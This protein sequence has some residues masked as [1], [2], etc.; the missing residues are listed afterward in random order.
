MR[1]PRP[2]SLDA[3][4]DTVLLEIIQRFHLHG[5]AVFSGAPLMDAGEWGGAMNEPNARALVAAGGGNETEEH[6][7]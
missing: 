2:T 1:H 3:E 6:N 5:P 7:L 4:L